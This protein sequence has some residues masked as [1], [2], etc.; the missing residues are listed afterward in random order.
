M[1]INGNRFAEVQ[2]RAEKRSL[3][4]PFGDLGGGASPHIGWGDTAT[5][6][7]IASVV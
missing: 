1:V 5:S 7:Q 4:N 3:P 6:C 2:R